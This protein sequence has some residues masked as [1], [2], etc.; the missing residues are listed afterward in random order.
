MCHLWL[1]IVW[2]VCLVVWLFGWLM[3][4]VLFVWLVGFVAIVCYVI[5]LCLLERFILCLGFVVYDLLGVCVFA[6][7]VDWFSWF[8][9]V[10]EYSFDIFCLGGCLGLFI[11]DL[12]CLFICLI[13]EFWFGIALLL[14]GWF[15]LCF[16]FCV[17]VYLF[18]YLLVAC[19][20]R[21]CV[22]CYLDLRLWWFSCLFANWCLVTL[23]LLVS[24]SVNYR[25]WVSV[26]LCGL[27]VVNL[28]V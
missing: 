16:W 7:L 26:K 17:S 21:W 18:W 1:I 8:K 25:F 19:L 15:G 6:V 3:I 14:L 27:R 13:V 22:G 4:W 9:R 12:V 20:I 23:D 11:L 2:V 5:N 10:K 24:L 28:L